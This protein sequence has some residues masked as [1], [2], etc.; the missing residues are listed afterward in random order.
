[1]VAFVAFFADAALARHAALLSS[2]QDLGYFDQAVWGTS[3]GHPLRLTVYD[4]NL[5]IPAQPTFLAYHVE[6]L[7]LLV[8]PLY[9]LWDDVRALLVLQP[10]V[11]A[12]AALPAYGL[13]RL[14][15][16]SRWGGLVI[17]LLVLLNP[18]IQA[19]P[20]NDFHTLAFAPLLLLGALL[21]LA[22]RRWLSLAGWGALAILVKEQMGLMVAGVGLAA[23]A[24]GLLHRWPGGRRQLIVGAG[25]AVGGAAWFLVSVTVVIPFFIGPAATESPFVARYSQ[26]GDGL[27]GMAR[28][29]LLRPDIAWSVTPKREVALYWLTLLLGGGL[30]PL[31]SPLTLLAAPELAIN[32]L[33]SF[34]AQRAMATHYSLSI[35]PFVVAGAADGAA[36]LVRWLARGD[37]KRRPRLLAGL[38]VVVLVVAGLNSLDRGFLP[39]ARKYHPAVPTPRD[40]EAAAWFARIPLDAPVMA[41]DRLVPHLT[42]RL[43]VYPFAYGFVP[44]VAGT[45]PPPEWVLLDVARAGDRADGRSLEREIFE[46]PDYGVVAADNGY[47]LLRRGVTTKELPPGFTRFALA[48][49]DEID[50]P[51]TATSEDGALTY[52]GSTAAWRPDP[53]SHRGWTVEIVSYWRANR[54]LDRALRFIVTDP[55]APGAPLFSRSPSIEWL[56]TTRWAVGQPIRVTHGVLALARPRPLAVAALEPEPAGALL[57]ERPLP[58]VPPAAPGLPGLLDRLVDQ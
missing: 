34:V 57:L 39:G 22:R 48:S 17:G 29:F 23:L 40:A 5:T 24:D 55:A 2:A 15:L 6:L 49:P 37:I 12:L 33:S 43:H 44:P 45:D 56:P 7:L 27:A 52:L 31:L 18:T 16:G 50:R 8:A 35:V 11:L 19:A 42:H 3:R 4:L 36:R 58:L 51:E 9:W 54:P 21:A 26:Y 38:L 1:M 32:S 47:L 14:W 46:H 13:G 30:A 25:L 53:W 20:V 41:S 10:I 28:T